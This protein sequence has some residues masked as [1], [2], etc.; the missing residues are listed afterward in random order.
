MVHSLHY[1]KEANI[2]LKRCYHQA[3]GGAFSKKKPIDFGRLK[4]EAENSRLITRDLILYALKLADLTER[5]EKAEDD[6]KNG[7]FSADD[8]HTQIKAIDDILSGAAGK[9]WTEKLK[10]F[11]ENRLTKLK[12][13]LKGIINYI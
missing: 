13:E 7:K 5:F 1:L 8:I 2:F 12:S 11:D 10:P 4:L 6:F 3:K 9:S